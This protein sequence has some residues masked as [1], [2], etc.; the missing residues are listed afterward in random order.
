MGEGIDL[1]FHA[2][3]IIEGIAIEVAELK[4][5]PLQDG[6]SKGC[7]NVD[8]DK[9]RSLEDYQAL[10]ALNEEHYVLV[11]NIFVYQYYLTFS[12]HSIKIGV[13]VAQIGLVLS[14]RQDFWQG[15]S[16]K[17]CF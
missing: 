4:G 16:T 5:I 6:A 11:I 9:D 12:V 7:G 17:E 3:V 13:K 2:Q 10:K 8:F 15:V 1:T 14:L